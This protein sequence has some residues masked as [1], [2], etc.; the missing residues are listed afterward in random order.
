MKWDTLKCAPI[1][2][3]QGLESS[4]SDKCTKASDMETDK[5]FLSYMHVVFC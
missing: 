1:E 5:Y 3:S 2:S 4:N